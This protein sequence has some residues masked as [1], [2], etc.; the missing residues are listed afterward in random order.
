MYGNSNIS[1]PKDEF[2]NI[3]KPVKFINKVKHLIKI[4]EADCP[5]CYEPIHHKTNACLTAC[6]HPVNKSCTSKWFIL[7]L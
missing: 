6:G 4:V 5:I 3:H 2:I 1:K 7:T